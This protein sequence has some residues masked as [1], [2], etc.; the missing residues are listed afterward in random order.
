MRYLNRRKILSD[1]EKK[2]YL[3]LEKGFLGEQLFNEWIEENISID[4]LVLHDLLLECNHTIFQIDTL[5]ISPEKIYIFEVKNYEGDFY[6]NTDKWY[7]ISE[8]EIKNPIHQLNRIETLLRRLIQNLGYNPSI[9]AKIIF[10]NPDF[11]LY[12]APINAPIIFP[13]QLNRFASTLNMKPF[14]IHNQQL[15][16]AE[17]LVALHLKDSP[18]KKLPTYSYSQLKKGIPCAVCDSFM[19]NLTLEML[20]CKQC[21]YKEHVDISV[22]RNIMEFKLLFPNRKV[23][24][25]IIHEWCTII[26]S[27]KTI[28]RILSRELKQMGHGKYTYYVDM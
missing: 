11:F 6:I 10:I 26:L 3:N 5:I 12:N 1:K 17:Q 14:N 2:Y 27:K 21:A 4:W 16:L 19:S 7:T 18:Y 25:N 23:T 24:T 8:V 28:Q 15:K 9:D 13:T 20:V 22:M